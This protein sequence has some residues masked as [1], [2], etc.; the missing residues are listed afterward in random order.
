MKLISPTIYAL[1][2]SIMKKGKRFMLFSYLKMCFLYLFH[3]QEMHCD[4]ISRALYNERVFTYLS[5]L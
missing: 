5:T 1:A 3:C 4:D 2:K